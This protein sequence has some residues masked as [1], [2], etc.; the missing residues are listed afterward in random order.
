MSVLTE[1]GL[2]MGEFY[3]SDLKRNGRNAEDL[4]FCTCSHQHLDGFSA[5]P[6]FDDIVHVGLFLERF[7]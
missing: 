3:K 5:L 7:Y 2:D 4:N 6:G 1:D